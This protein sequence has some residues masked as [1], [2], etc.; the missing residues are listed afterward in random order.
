VEGLQ[1][2]DKKAVKAIVQKCWSAWESRKEEILK[3]AT[4]A[5]PP[6]KK[7]KR[8]MLVDLNEAMKTMESPTPMPLLMEFTADV[9]VVRA[10]LEANINAD[11]LDE[12]Y[13]ALAEAADRELKAH[14]SNLELV[15][16]GAVTKMHDFASNTDMQQA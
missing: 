1:P 3:F 14:D 4:A 11:H 8:E 6:L 2:N 10:R 5:I 7:A 12:P 13:E 16:D 9:E 15:K